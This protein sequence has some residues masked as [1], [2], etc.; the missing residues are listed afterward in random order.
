MV[1]HENYRWPGRVLWK[2][3]E[4]Y[5][6]KFVKIKA[7]EEHTFRIPFWDAP[8]S[9]FAGTVDEDGVEGEVPSSS[10]FILSSYSTFKMGQW[11]ILRGETNKSYLVV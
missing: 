1:R 5:S 7:E 10:I 9:A 8:L 2:K 3:G 4:R 11:E 6:K